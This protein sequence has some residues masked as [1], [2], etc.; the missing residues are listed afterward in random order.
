MI[1]VKEQ[2]KTLLAKSG[3]RSKF[4][5]DADD[6]SYISGRG[7]AVLKTHA[8]DFIGRRLAP[9]QPKNEGKQT[10]VKGHPVFKAQHA[11]A[12]CCRECLFKWY[13]FPK[14]KML[15]VKQVDAIVDTIMTWLSE[16]T[17][18]FERADGVKD[19]R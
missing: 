13:G 8:K 1:G 5:L 17:A 16:Q 6:I 14:N 4:Q 19:I 9:A 15:T 7:L 11:T 10:P 2:K 3:F 12:T 18:R